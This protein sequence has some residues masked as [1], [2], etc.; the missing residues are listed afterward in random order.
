[1]GY[2]LRLESIYV[3]NMN[4]SHA[5][6]A[7][8]NEQMEKMAMPFQRIEAVDGKALSCVEMA[9]HCSQFSK[10][11]VPQSVIGCALSHKKA[12][13]TMIDNGDPYALILEVLT[14]CDIAYSILYSFPFIYIKN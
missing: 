5:R 11:F 12:W 13:Q 4:K 9:K 6:L 10:E 2:A 1:V 14:V 8:M 7:Q 3:I